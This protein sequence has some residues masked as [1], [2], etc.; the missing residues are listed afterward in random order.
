MGRSPSRREYRDA[1]DG[2]GYD[3]FRTGLQYGEVRAMMYSS[4]DDPREWRYRR[5]H[6]VLG[7]WR[8]LKLQL[9]QQVLEAREVEEVARAG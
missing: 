8:Q 1:K 4:S 7:F 6:T 5:R 3:G 2:H 9:W